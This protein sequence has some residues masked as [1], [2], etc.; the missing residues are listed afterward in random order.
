MVRWKR[1]QQDLA[2]TT[3]VTGVDAV[4]GD[5]RTFGGNIKQEEGEWDTMYDRLQAFKVLKGHCQPDRETDDPA[6]AQWGKLNSSIVPLSCFADIEC[7]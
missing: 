6:L 7:R 4:G 3:A 2:T 1:S 5:A